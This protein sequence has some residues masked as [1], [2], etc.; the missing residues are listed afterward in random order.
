MLLAGNQPAIGQYCTGIGIVGRLHII[1]F[2]ISYIPTF[3]HFHICALRRGSH[4]SEAAAGGSWQAK[5]Q[6]GKPLPPLLHK[7]AQEQLLRFR[8]RFTVL[9]QLDADRHGGI[10][11]GFAWGRFGSVAAVRF[12]GQTG[13]GR[14]S[15]LVPGV[16]RGGGRARSLRSHCPPARASCRCRTARSGNRPSPS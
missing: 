1:T 13:S 8:C 10:L 11:C 3:L 14:A 7:S 6:G 16:Q 4:D 15:V 2:V 12:G 9:P 5:Q